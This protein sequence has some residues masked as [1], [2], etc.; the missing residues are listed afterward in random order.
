MRILSPRCG[1]RVSPLCL[2]AMSIGENWKD[3]MGAQPSSGCW[4]AWYDAGSMDKEQS[5]ALLD[6]FLKAGGSFLDTSSNY[7]GEESEEWIGEWMETRG[8]RDEMVIATK[9]TTVRLRGA[10]TLC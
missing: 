5:F 1:L 6:A 2:G 10:Q 9:Y 3:F 4:Q 7:Q 8:I